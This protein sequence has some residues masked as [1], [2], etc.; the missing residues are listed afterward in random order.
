MAWEHDRQLV[1]ALAQ[2]AV[3]R[4]APEE[5][6]QFE[7]TADAFFASSS[8]TRRTRQRDDPLA[9]GLDSIVVLTSTVAL[10]VAVEVLKHLAT[11]YSEKALGGLWRRVR[12]ITGRRAE[13]DPLAAPPLPQLTGQQLAELHALAQQKALA[14]Q[15]PSDLAVLLADGIVAE[16]CRS[17]TETNATPGTAPDTTSGTASG[18]APLP[19]SDPTA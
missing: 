7:V 3:T 15:L 17:S 8:R 4:A 1:T 6:S 11:D 5:L 12:S 18:P 10:S 14:A 19:D 13:S 2:A 9:L 16:L